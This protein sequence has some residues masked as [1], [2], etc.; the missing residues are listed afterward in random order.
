MS[1]GEVAQEIVESSWYV[2]EVEEEFKRSSGK[3]RG[4]GRVEVEKSM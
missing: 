2:P 3:S 4:R 1:W